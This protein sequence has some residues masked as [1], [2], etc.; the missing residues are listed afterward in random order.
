M[1]PVYRLLV[2]RVNETSL[3]LKGEY[4][5]KVSEKWKMRRIS[6]HKRDELV[7]VILRSIVT[8]IK[9]LN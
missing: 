7:D 3:R 4:R 5:L 9:T 6:G 2:L 8:C 1:K